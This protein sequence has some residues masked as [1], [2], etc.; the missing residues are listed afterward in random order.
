VLQLNFVVKHCNVLF[1]TLEKNAVIDLTRTRNQLLETI[2]ASP[3]AGIFLK[4]ATDPRMLTA[5]AHLLIRGHTRKELFALLKVVLSERFIQ[6]PRP[7]L[8]QD[9]LA[10]L[11]NALGNAW[12]HGN[13]RDPAKSI[14]VECEFSDKGCLIAITDEGA[15]FDADI[16]AGQMREP[17]AAVTD[18]GAGFRNFERAHSLVSYENGGR[19]TLL[20]FRPEHGTCDDSCVPSSPERTPLPSRVLDGE[21]MRCRLSAELPE[22]N[23]GGVTLEEC[24]VYPGAGRGSDL[25]GIRYILQIRKPAEGSPEARILTGRM[26]ATEAEAEAEFRNATR[27]AH[28]PQ[29]KQF[30]IPRAVARLADEPGL[31]LFDFDPWL[32]LGEYFDDRGTTE[33]I[34]RCAE[35]LGETLAVLHKSEIRL[36]QPEYEPLSARFRLTC[37]SIMSVLEISRHDADLVR[38]FHAIADCAVRLCGPLEKR[39]PVPVHGALGWD[40]IYYGV[41]GRFYLY[42]LE[43]CRL[44]DPGVDLGGFLAGLLLFTAQRDDEES[45]RLGREAFLRSYDSAFGAVT[46]RENLRAWIAITMVNRFGCHLQRLPADSAGP[47]PAFDPST[48]VPLLI[49]RCETVLYGSA[50]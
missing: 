30:R 31:V 28:L 50:F 35:R 39:V 18:R 48:S 17:A 14:Q 10:P 36:P 42:R 45:W 34:C 24:H 47:F 49:S 22:I 26:H 2:E 9:L 40:S 4:E 43:N 27:L 7:Q 20:C 37:A 16:V 21:W 44:S 3:T 12:K 41:D 5:D 13:E 6:V 19:T 8:M 32:S 38:R 23:Q 11:R 33:V 29:S 46:D 25:C 15:G 1:S